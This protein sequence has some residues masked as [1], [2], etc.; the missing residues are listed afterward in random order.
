MGT[1]DSRL[2]ACTAVRGNPSS[3]KEAEDLSDFFVD[4]AGDVCVADAEVEEMLGVGSSHPL[5]VSS[6][7]I[8]SRIV[9]SGTSCP[10]SRADWTLS[11]TSI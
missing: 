11:P 7:D 4:G 10:V 1:R 8:S 2:L 6:V 5:V 3:I 9:A